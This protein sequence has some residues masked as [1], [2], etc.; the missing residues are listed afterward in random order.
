MKFEKTAGNNPTQKLTKTEQ[1]KLLALS[2][3]S[4]STEDDI[5]IE[6]FDLNM[7]TDVCCT[8]PG[9]LQNSGNINKSF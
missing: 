4:M 1:D 8:G 6:F 2:S 9:C 3:V 5:E 7:V